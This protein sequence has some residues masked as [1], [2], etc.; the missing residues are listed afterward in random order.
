MLEMYL[1]GTAALTE[2][3]LTSSDSRATSIKP[4]ELKGLGGLRGT[5]PEEEFEHNVTSMFVRKR[6][7]KVESKKS[8]LFGLPNRNLLGI[9]E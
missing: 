8:S 1:R 7:S 3:G 2:Q 4:M 9:V 6:D 5:N